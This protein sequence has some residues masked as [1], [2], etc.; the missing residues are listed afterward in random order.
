MN[1]ETAR[2]RREIEL[3]RI[4]DGW[5]QT[6]RDEAASSRTSEDGSPSPFRHGA[7]ARPASYGATI[8]AVLEMPVAPIAVTATSSGSVEPNDSVID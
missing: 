1:S 2:H 4:V 5:R 6:A 3:I 8:V 7:D